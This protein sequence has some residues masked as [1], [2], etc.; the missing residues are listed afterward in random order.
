MEIQ[1]V[2]LTPGSLAKM[3]KLI[4]NGT[5]SGKIAKNIIKEMMMMMMMMTGNDI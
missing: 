3:L 2:R 4:D 1:D 5:I